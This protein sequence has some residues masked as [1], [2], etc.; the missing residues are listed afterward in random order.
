MRLARLARGLGEHQREQGPPGVPGQ[1]GGQG[2]GALEVRGDPGER[3][4]PGFA[5]GRLDPDGEAGLADGQDVA[6]EERRGPFDRP[7]VEQGPAAEEVDH[8]GRRGPR[9]RAQCVLEAEASS[10][11][12]A[13]ASPRPTK[14]RAEPSIQGGP[15]ASSGSRVRPARAE[16][17]ASASGSSSESGGSIAEPSTRSWSS[18]TRRPATS[19]MSPAPSQA[20]AAAAPGEPGPGPAQE[21]NAEDPPAVEEQEGMAAVDGRVVDPDVGAGELAD[22][23]ERPADPDDPARLG[24]RPPDPDRELAVNPERPANLLADRHRS[25]LPEHAPAPA[26]IPRLQI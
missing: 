10:I 8:V 17:S 25:T 20:E 22:Q 15:G 19:R 11:R 26:R 21:V 6:V 14:A 13:Q 2:R 18:S 12:M 4:G 1:L 5:P 23:R 9:S 3:P 24:P 7:V 16:G